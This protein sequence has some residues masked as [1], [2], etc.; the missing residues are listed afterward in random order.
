MLLIVHP[1]FCPAV[2]GTILKVHPRHIRVGSQDA[3]LNVLSLSLPLL[4]SLPPLP[5]LSLPPPP[6]SHGMHEGRHLGLQLRLP[7]AAPNCPQGLPTFGIWNNLGRHLSDARQETGSV[8]QRPGDCPGVRHF[9]GTHSPDVPLGLGGRRGCVSCQKSE[10][11]GGSVGWWGS[12]RRGRRCLSSVLVDHLQV[13]LP[14]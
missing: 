6:P 8:H 5:P 10:E 4:I 13:M 3:I 11:A 7:L 1:I 14:D 2:P 12:G 9:G